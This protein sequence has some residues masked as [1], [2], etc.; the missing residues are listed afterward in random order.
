MPSALCAVPFP[1]RVVRLP[2]ALARAALLP[3]S[4]LG[5]LSCAHGGERAADDDT[6][7][8]GSATIAGDRHDR[9]SLSRLTTL[10]GGPLP[11]PSSDDDVGVER[12]AFEVTRAY[13]TTP[14]RLGGR[15]TALR[16][17]AWKGRVHT[18]ELTFPERCDAACARSLASTLEAW[19][20]PLAAHQE[21][22]ARF[23]SGDADTVQVTLEVYPSRPDLTRVILRCGPLW[24]AS[25]GRP[26][27][28]PGFGER[29]VVDERPRCRPLP[30]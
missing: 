6:H 17:T 8:S 7:R 18:A 29:P 23:L 22:R 15:A 21:G 24:S 2:G 3:L 13:A 25:Q 10:L 14:P 5:A 16:L 4:L 1:A 11:T 28:L 9:A 26:S 20:G 27:R 30:P 12:P 19:A